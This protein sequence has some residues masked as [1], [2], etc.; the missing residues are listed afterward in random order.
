MS[1]MET[2]GGEQ[3]PEA[4]AHPQPLFK[5]LRDAAPVVDLGPEIMGGMMIVGGDED[6]RHV[7]QH[8][9]IFSSGVDAVDIG[10]VRPL[11]PLQIDPPEHKNF[12]KLLDPIFAPK[13]VALLEDATRT[14]VKRP[15]RRG[16]G[17]GRLQLPQGR[18]RAAAQHGVPPAARPARVAHRRVRRS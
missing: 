14:L 18:G 2:M 16:D 17:Q 6:V 7:L 3:D 15:R 11:I 8:P 4:L 10:Q 9:E 13:Q 12:R 5:L 1:D